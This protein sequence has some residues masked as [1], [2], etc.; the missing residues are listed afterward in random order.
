M[1]SNEFDMLQMRLEEMEP[2][3]DWFLVVE[4][5]VDHQNHPKPYHL[6]ENLERF[7]PWRS[8]LI[9]VRATGL[10]TTEHKA[11]PWAREWAQRD[12]VWEGLKQ[13]PGL[14][15]TDIVLHGDV[16][17]ICRPFFV[18]NIRP[19]A[20]EFVAF[21]QRMHCFAVDWQ[22]PEMWGGTV[23]VT[24]E[25]ATMIGE[26]REVDGVLWHPGAWQ[27]VR[28]QRNRI[29]PT[30]FYQWE[31]RRVCPECRG[32][33]RAPVEDWSEDLCRSCWGVGTVT[34]LKFMPLH[35]AGWH[36]TW[37]GGQ[38][39]QQAKLE[40]FCHPEVA[41]RIQ[42]GLTND[43]Y[44]TEGFHADGTKLLPVDVDDTWPAMIHE[45]RCPESWWRPR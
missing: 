29:V 32:S 26:R 18:R 16:D 14:A 6:S 34:D 37:L 8:K 5:D 45:R 2:A 22:H 36:F 10:P 12:W 11:D 15:P 42:V 39:A 28:N 3:V 30:N 9:V 23:A 4:A 43:T 31:P 19:K 13:V 33:R 21:G 38:E 20:R 1:F 35:D 44:M 17:E 41:Q 27:I 24:V 25:T 7:S 40:S